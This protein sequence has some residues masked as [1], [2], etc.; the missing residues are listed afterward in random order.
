MVKV[1]DEAE[2][3]MKMTEA[4]AESTLPG[5][6]PP[7]NRFDVSKMGSRVMP[8]AL[9]GGGAIAL[10][11]FGLSPVHPDVF[12]VAI[13][14]SA[15]LTVV[16][17][18]AGVRP[19]PAWLEPVL[20]LLGI[21]I[22]GFLRHGAGNDE[23]GFSLLV[24]IPVLWLA[25]FATR[26]QLTTGL[27]LVAVVLAAPV[28]LIGSPEYPAAEWRH[29][30]II[31]MLSLFVGFTIQSLVADIR[32]QAGTLIVQS[33]ALATEVAFTRAVIDGATDAIVVLDGT[34]TVVEANA[35]AAT[36][37]GRP[38]PDI[39]GL[40][41]ARDII[42]PTRREA[43]RS[44]LGRIAAGVATDREQRFETELLRGD[45]TTVPAEVT[46]AITRGPQGLRIYAFAR[47]IS[48]RREAER[49]ADVH[50]DDLNRLLRVARDLGRGESIEGDRTAICVAAR[51]LAEADMT[52]FFEYRAA[53]DILVATGRSNDGPDPGAVE[54]HG[55]SS[56]T[57]T[58]FA[59]GEAAFI[60]DL[61]DDPRI[62]QS[63]VLRLSARS[64]L[65]QPIL[66][67]GRPLGVLVVYWRE[68]VP[69]LAPRIASMTELF[70]TQAAVVIERADLIARLDVL[71]RTDALTGA[72]NR[73]ALEES[74]LRDLAQ[75]DRS[76]APLSIVMLDLDHFKA[77]ND[78]NGHP[79]GDRLLRG[80]VTTWRGELRVGDT[81]ARYGGEE[82]LI[83]LPGCAA[84]TAGR[85]ADRIRA[86]V[87]SGQTVSAGVAAWDGV[88]SMTELIGRADAALYAAKDAGRN[89]TILAEAVEPPPPPIE[90]AA[91]RRSARATGS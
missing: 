63:I 84:A 38:R 65:F 20:P 90:L 78:A 85:L 83:V 50:L 14:L 76:Q 72:A 55:R 68:P 41:L 48:V 15:L 32:L 31:V 79:A 88:E 44:G 69:Q 27:V 59:T 26:R 10:A 21:V 66:A 81:L 4:A 45:G 12:V 80:A 53:D 2:D 19:M 87:P 40:E 39:L 71:A 60:P 25:M 5:R 13:A 49:V 75:A 34:G 23:V 64:A 51:D 35:A 16:G 22:V 89:R 47:D 37:L 3:R 62:D 17:A 56:V 61:A 77:F 7:T 36:I 42:S 46:T 33:N 24:L 57:A 30:G 29:V 82:F 1:A 11:L 86:A 67:E 6:L 58:V 8:F 73:R 52:L 43:A 54:V 91:R 18:I 28:A 74:F 70:A 9:G